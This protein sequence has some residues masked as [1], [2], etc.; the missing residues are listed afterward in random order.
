MWFRNS[1]CGFQRQGPN[2]PSLKSDVSINNKASL[3]IETSLLRSENLGVFRPNFPSLKSDVSI[4]N[5]ASLLIETS[6]L[7]LE[8]LGLKKKRPENLYA[9]FVIIYIC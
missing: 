8:N 7:R 1:T 2:F 5:K 3:L 6:L 4:N 9:L